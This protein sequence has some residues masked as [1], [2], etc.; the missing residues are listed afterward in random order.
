M[1]KD[2]TAFSR[3]SFLK[4]SILSGGGM[5]LTVS[6]LSSFKSADKTQV[7]GLPEQW[8]TLNGYIHILPDN[9][10]KLICPNP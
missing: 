3:R 5:M 10:V 7:L 9:K 1:D 4:A 2:K 6:W 8:A